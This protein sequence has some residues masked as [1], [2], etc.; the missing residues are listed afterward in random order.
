MKGFLLIAL[1]WGASSAAHGSSP[2][3]LS[4]TK[5]VPPKLAVTVKNTSADRNLGMWIGGSWCEQIF[6]FEVF[7]K[8]GKVIAKYNHQYW[9]YTGNIP[10]A[11]ALKPGETRAIEFDLSDKKSWIQPEKV[12]LN[13]PEEL[14]FCAVLNQPLDIEAHRRSVFTGEVKSP[15]TSTTQVDGTGSCVE[16]NALPKSD[17]GPR[18]DSAAFLETLGKL[19]IS[20]D[21]AKASLLESLGANLPW[22]QVA[23][24]SCPESQ[25]KES[26][27]TATLLLPGAFVVALQ[28]DTQESLSTAEKLQ[29]SKCLKL[30]KFGDGGEG[31]PGWAV[32][33]EILPKLPAHGI[34]RIRVDG[35]GTV[36]NATGDFAGFPG[37]TWRL[38]RD[39]SYRKE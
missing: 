5:L 17:D 25:F 21:N 20:E 35:P 8:A 11:Y 24:I 37:Q 6:H 14:S 13:N 31:Q 9:D 7:D 23:F 38:Q 12:D 22:D 36:F 4:I 27:R 26:S 30:A 19:R 18:F 16:W 32:A 33:S 29:L 3:E 39:G 28:W 2:L 1:M 10:L 15:R 34:T